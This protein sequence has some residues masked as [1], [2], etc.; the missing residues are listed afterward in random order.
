MYSKIHLTQ[1]AFQLCQFLLFPTL[2]NK[3]FGALDFHTRKTAS[4]SEINLHKHETKLKLRLSKTNR[5]FYLCIRRAH[6][7]QCELIISDT[8]RHTVPTKKR[9]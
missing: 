9:Q 2:T 7:R 4:I 5:V 8:Q 3:S 6:T 1:T